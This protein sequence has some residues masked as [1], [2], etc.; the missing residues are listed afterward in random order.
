MK[1][2]TMP[3]GHA[4]RV[5]NI[6]KRFQTSDKEIVAISDLSFDAQ[7]GEFISV[8]GPSGCGKST[9]FNIIGGFVGDYDGQ[10]LLDDNSAISRRSIG[11]VFQE[12]STFPW[13]TTIQN[14]MLP[15]ET[16]GT[17]KAER[18]DRARHFI[19]LV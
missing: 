15:L 9:L 10:V 13:R 17:P 12:E 11:T 19:K 14:V 8:I 3:A 6:S 16:I 18:L 1:A 2:S 5:L 4:L 7:P